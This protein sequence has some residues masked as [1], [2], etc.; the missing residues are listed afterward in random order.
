MGPGGFGPQHFV[1]ADSTLA[2]RIEFENYGPGSLNPDGLP[3]TSDRWATAPAQRVVIT[4]T[5]APTLDLGTFLITGFGF[6]DF[7][8]S[9]A[10]PA[11]SFQQIL[12]MTYNNRT[13]DV[14]FEGAIDYAAR[15]LSFAFQSIDPLTGLPPDV[16]TGFLPPEDGTGRGM[17]FVTY[18]VRA[19]AGL[20]T[21]T[22]IRNIALI[23]FD[24][25]TFI[26]TNQVDP[27]HPEK[28]TD[29]EREALVTLD[30]GRP[31]S[32]VLTLPARTNA[33]SFSVSWSGQDDETGSGIGTYA[34]FVSI[35]GGGFTR[36][37]SGTADTQA[38]FTGEFGHTYSFYSVATDNAGNGQLPPTSAQATTFLMPDAPVLTSSIINDGSTQRSMVNSL[39]V[40]FSSAVTLE[41]GAITISSYH[42][43]QV[44]TL[45]I[46]NPTGDGRTYLIRFAGISVV[47]G[48]LADGIYDVTVHG[49]RV[50]DQFNQTMGED[51]SVRFHRLFGDT[52]GDRDV[53]QT[54]LSRMKQSLGSVL[55]DKAYVWWLDYNA[56]GA[57]S[58]GDLVQFMQRY[59]NRFPWF[60]KP[61]RV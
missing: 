46:T 47:G 35:D 27:L 4:N 20:P 58:G 40:V 30:A 49:S 24:N 36:W 56:D 8:I 41:A 57:I 5:L 38:I 61:V 50:R 1:A 48:S 14:W 44:L 11:Q 23:S 52:D 45:N 55:G 15:Q 17:G 9:L 51:S 42:S 12:T 2:Y 22:E 34:V 60:E 10:T 37:L 18:V 32:S 43:N 25:Q 59:G 28:G 7:N 21:G 6:G 54:D 3:V 19:L 29:T 53:D 31:T 39:T 26:A 13:F 33:T 16:L